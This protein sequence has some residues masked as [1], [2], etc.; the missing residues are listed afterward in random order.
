[1]FLVS[2]KVKENE[3]KRAV[4][5]PRYN[6]DRNVA[7]IGLTN[8]WAKNLVRLLLASWS[9]LPALCSLALACKIS[10]QVLP[11]SLGHGLELIKGTKREDKCVALWF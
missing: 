3:V 2:E 7:G 4:T 1:M 6:V 10:S 5:T 8:N 11:G 9:I